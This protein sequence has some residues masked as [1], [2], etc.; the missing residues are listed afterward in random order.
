M[1]CIGDIGGKNTHTC[2]HGHTRDLI[3][4]MFTHSPNNYMLR[5]SATT[6]T[7]KKHT[8]YNFTL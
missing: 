8:L 7:N 6:T 3:T 5:S 4:L 1:H 2:T